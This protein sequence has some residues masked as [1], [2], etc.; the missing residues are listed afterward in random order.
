[1]FIQRVAEPR[2]PKQATAVVITLLDKLATASNCLI[3]AYCL[4]AP[5]TLVLRMMLN[6]G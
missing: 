3:T 1:M 5:L 4:C 6:E 2:G